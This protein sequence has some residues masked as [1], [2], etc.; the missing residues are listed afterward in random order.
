[1]TS[2]KSAIPRKKYNRLVCSLVVALLFPGVAANGQ[3]LTPSPARIDFDNVRVGANSQTVTLTNSGTGG[4]SVT[5]SAASASGAGFSLSGLSLP[6][7]LNAGQSTS[8]TVAFA[9]TGV[10]A[11]VGTVTI[12]SNAALSNLTI[13]LSGTVVQ[14]KLSANLASITFANLQVQTSSSQTETLTNS[15]GTA[16]IIASI[17]A[18]GA[19]FSLSGLSTPQTLNAGDSIPFTVTFTPNS[20]GDIKGSIII[21]S[22]AKNTDLRI[23][24]FGTGD[25]IQDLPECSLAKTN[26]KCKLI[27]DRT[28]PVAP[29]TIQM[30][31]NQVLTVI[32]KNAK[33]FERYFL[34]YQSG[35]ATL[36]PD[37]ASGVVQGLLPSLAKINEFYAFDAT[38]G[39]Q[40]QADQCSAPWLPD[41]P[42]DLSPLKGQI[43]GMLPAFRRCVA[44][45]AKNAVPIYHQL[46]PFVAPDSL[47]K[48]TAKYE[49]LMAVKRRIHDFLASEFTMSGKITIISGN[50]AMKA[51][52]PDSAALLELGDLQKMADAVANDL[53]GYS[54]RIKDLQ[55]PD[56][57]SAE[58]ASID[59]GRW[60][61]INSSQECDNTI[62]VTTE[63]E[64]SK[65]QC[66]I[67]TSNQDDEKIY[68][69]M[70]T[71]TITYAL[72]TLN[73]VSN[74]Q[75]AA[76]DP[77]KK[78]SLASIPI[79]FADSPS[80]PSALRWEASAGTFFSSLPVRSFSVAPVF[81][82]GAITNNIIAQ[83]LLHPTVVPFGAAN[84]RISNDLGWT[85]WKSAVYLTGAVG[86]N[87]NTVS[88][89]FASGLSI[90]WRSLMFSP[91]WHYGHDV[92]LA[93]GLYVG[94]SLGASFKGSLATQT[95]WKSSFA[96]GVSIRV[97]PLTGR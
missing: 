85:R 92:R 44:Q 7:S 56:N 70:V 67:I 93:Q 4:T 76:P 80:K 75:Q 18:S 53:L 10:G 71:R 87:P 29:P 49:D 39:Q 37:V 20:V 28:I 96:F 81:T 82:S 73:L 65:I 62:I 50:A 13:P 84:Y 8:F 58:C 43:A 38:G 83:N 77:T 91:L 11:A 12:T 88:A 33:P 52:N 72:N 89:D 14:G 3:Q 36:T 97:P 32:I 51:S 74:S 69:Q 64:N 34:D 60:K 25:Q 94:E 59:A 66:V 19:G 22:D 42:P 1:M 5:I 90:S 47:P 46:E 61:N 26:K 79:N 86:V 35:Q 27:I 17:S 57:S 95:Y 31:S 6:L 68:H 24:L 40:A 55:C 41:L 23:P 2:A 45:L 48:V 15:G 9:P 54:L 21:T 16:V 30:Y 78:K 63:E